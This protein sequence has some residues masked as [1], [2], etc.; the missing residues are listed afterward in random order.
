MVENKD[1]RTLIDPII[2]KSWH[3]EIAMRILLI[4]C[5][6]VPVFA[7]AQVEVIKDPR[8]DLV[9]AKQE[10]LNKK[11][12]LENN[13]SAP[14][15][16]V[17]VINTNDRSKAF[18]IKTRLMRDYPDHKTYLVYQSPYFKILIGNFRIKTDA[19]ALQKQISRHYPAG[20]I[21]V[22]TLVE[23]KPGEDILAN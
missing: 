22:P 10:E 23:L 14:G 6:V 19:D 4:I 20:V 1:I 17:L 11:V 7:T 9:L 13:R 16:R 2:G 8:L 18:E 21:V 5:F 15:F 12:F 3:L